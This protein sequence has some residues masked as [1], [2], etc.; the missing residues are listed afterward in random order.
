MPVRIESEGARPRRLLEPPHS[1][2]ARS[3]GGGALAVQIPRAR[4]ASTSH[5]LEAGTSRTAARSWAL[6]TTE[7]LTQVFGR[8]PLAERGLRVSRKGFDRRAVSGSWAGRARGGWGGRWPAAALVGDGLRFRSPAG[9]HPAGARA[10]ARDPARRGR[11]PGRG[12][13][14]VRV[15]RPRHLPPGG[16][17]AGVWIRCSRSSSSC[18]NATPPSSTACSGGASWICNDY[19]DDNGSLFAVLTAEQQV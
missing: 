9:S 18:G 4:A 13:R 6:A 17:P 10:R 19:I 16:A 12:V 8:R 3:W 14:R 7:Q 2:V 5:V 11:I 1:R 15:L